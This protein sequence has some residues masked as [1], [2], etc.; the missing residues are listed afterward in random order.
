MALSSNPTKT[1][2]IEK[3]F[4]RENRKRFALFNNY[5]TQ[6]VRASQSPQGVI[7]NADGDFSLTEA[8]IAQLMRLLRRQAYIDIIG[9]PPTAQFNSELEREQT[10][11]WQS[12]YI[13]PSY[14]RG[15]VTSE[16]QLAAGGV[17]IAM[18]T[19]ELQQLFGMR[20]PQQLELLLSQ[21]DEQHQEGARKIE[22]RAYSSLVGQTEQMISQIRSVMESENNNTPTSNM[23]AL[24][25]QRVSAANSGGERIASTETIQAFQTSQINTAQIREDE[26]G[27]EIK[28]RWLT[29]D[30]SKV[31]RLHAGWHGKVMTKTEAAHNINESPWNCR[32][33]FAMVPP[34]ADTE[35][36]QA[37][38]DKERKQLLKEIE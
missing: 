38:F 10:D 30:D 20:E 37:M 22:N 18:S 26:T 15:V 6:L 7:S 4:R 12:Q 29:R 8:G 32:C 11:Q 5:M 9:A 28:L 17:T 14:L 3:A 1:R 21:M 13:L 24:L 36:R 2:T 16:R 31:R 35:K 27:E 33:G 25:Q 19:E 34:N 23:I